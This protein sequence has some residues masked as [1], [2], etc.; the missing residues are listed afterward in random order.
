[1]AGR[2]YYRGDKQEEGYQQRV[3]CARGRRMDLSGGQQ[4]SAGFKQGSDMVR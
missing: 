3:L 1:M 2:T 4:P